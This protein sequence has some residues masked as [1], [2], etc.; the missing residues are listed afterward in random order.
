M[1]GVINCLLAHAT[2]AHTPSFISTSFVINLIVNPLNLFNFLLMIGV[3]NC[4]LAH[5][6][7]A[8]VAAAGLRAVLELAANNPPNKAR[9]GR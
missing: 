7:S 6:T 8:R 5:A 3:I 4:L 2:S 1:V 9:L